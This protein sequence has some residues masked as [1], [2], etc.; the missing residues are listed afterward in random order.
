MACEHHQFS[1]CM[2]L[3]HHQR[4][5]SSIPRSH[6]GAEGRPLYRALCVEAPELPP[7]P[8]SLDA[9]I[10]IPDRMFA[11]RRNRLKCKPRHPF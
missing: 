1:D 10:G 9:A 11:D 2:Q 4:H 3:A 6:Q 8:Y 7:C 5:F